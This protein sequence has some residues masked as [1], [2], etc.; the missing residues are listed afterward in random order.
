[1]RLT[2]L[3]HFF[4]TYSYSDFIKSGR[5]FA[6]TITR[7]YVSACISWAT[8]LLQ[9]ASFALFVMISANFSHFD[10][11]LSTLSFNL[12]ISS[13]LSTRDYSA[14]ILLLNEFFSFA[15]INLLLPNFAFHSSIFRPDSCT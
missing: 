9:P 15:S 10:F 6:S 12:S 1:M 2:R 5:L 7:C 13:R 8:S 11:L 3:N 14:F 4:S